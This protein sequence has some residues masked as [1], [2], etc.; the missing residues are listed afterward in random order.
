MKYL[1]ILALLALS[2]CDKP[3]DLTQFSSKCVM[4]E[5]GSQWMYYVLVDS[6]GTQYYVYRISNKTG[7]K[8]D[9]YWIDAWDLDGAVSVNCRKFGL[10]N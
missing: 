5:S 1:L 8:T 2:A 4:V 7:R 10:N 3:A 9:P 6:K